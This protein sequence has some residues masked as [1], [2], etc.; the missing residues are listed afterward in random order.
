MQAEPTNYLKFSK[1]LKEE[2]KVFNNFATIMEK[3]DMDGY[4]QKITESLNWVLSSEIGFAAT[5]HLTRTPKAQGKEEK[6]RRQ[7][8]SSK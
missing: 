8:A 7:A 1:R 6:P 2:S 5:G 3:A 4:I